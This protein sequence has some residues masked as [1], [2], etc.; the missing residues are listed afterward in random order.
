MSHTI[1][2]TAEITDPIDAQRYP[3]I[4]GLRSLQ[5]DALL[6]LNDGAI[7]LVPQERATPEM[8]AFAKQH[9]NAIA[10]EIQSLCFEPQSQPQ[11]GRWVDPRHYQDNRLSN[12][13]DRLF[14]YLSA[15][16]A[17]P[18]AYW[19]GPPEPKPQTRPYCYINADLVNSPT[20]DSHYD[21]LPMLADV[22]G[23]DYYWAAVEQWD[24]CAWAN[25]E[26]T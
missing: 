13:M 1:L 4:A 6:R 26:A 18:E 24:Y 12:L 11:D 25:Q 2:S 22:D 8:L 23:Q 10:A 19:D 3:F 9:R 15:S 7:G 17:P 14:A 16:G 20:G 5:M 21:Y